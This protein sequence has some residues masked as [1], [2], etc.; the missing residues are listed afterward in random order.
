V[1]CRDYADLLGLDDP[2]KARVAYISSQLRSV[3]PTSTHA[4][5][6]VVVDWVNV[7]LTIN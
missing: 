1:N 7:H 4:L 2:E 5:A 3:M 6:A